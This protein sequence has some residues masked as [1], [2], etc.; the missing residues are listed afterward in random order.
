MIVILTK[1]VGVL[2][3]R[4]SCNVVYQEGREVNFSASKAWCECHLS[5]GSGFFLARPSVSIILPRESVF[6]ANEA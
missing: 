4:P 3:A 5:G 1:R 2:L 6:V